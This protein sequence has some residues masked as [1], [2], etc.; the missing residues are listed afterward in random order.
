MEAGYANALHQE[1]R[2][3]LLNEGLRSEHE[4]SVV[5]ETGRKNTPA[6]GREVSRKVRL[7]SGKV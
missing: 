5:V 2:R 6:S 1:R 4:M 3:W 7:G